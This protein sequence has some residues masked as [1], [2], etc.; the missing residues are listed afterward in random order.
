MLQ[1]TKVNFNEIEDRF[2]S[3][4]YQ[5][6]YIKP[7]RIVKERGVEIRRLGDLATRID[8]DPNFYNVQYVSDGIPVVRGVDIHIPFI[9]F[10]FSEKIT[11]ETH[12]KYQRTEVY[13]GDIIMT[14]R[15]VVG[16]TG[17]IPAIVK[18]ANISP[19]VILIRLKD[20]E[21]VGYVNLI[22]SSK[23]GRSQIKRVTV[24]SIQ[25]T[26]TVPFIE[27]LPIPFSQKLAQEVDNILKKAEKDHIK[28][29]LKL[30]EAKKLFEDALNINH[31]EVKEEK[32][33][34]VDS[35]DLTDILTPKFYYPKFLNT[36]KN[37]KKKFKTVKLGEISN[38]KRGNEVGSKNYHKYID[39]KESDIPFIRTSDLVNYEID[40]YPDYY[41]DEK[42]YNESRQDLR[43]DDLLVSNDGKIGLLAIL[44]PED[45]CIIQSHIRRVRVR[46]D[47]NPYYVLTF[48]ATDFGQ[49]QFQQYSFTQA[50]IP[51]ISDRLAE[52]EIPI[53]NNQ[54]QEK[55]SQ[56][57]KEAFLLKTEK[58]KLFR[59]ALKKVEEITD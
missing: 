10:T 11:S 34:F 35:A 23:F 30:E 24:K 49:Y 16:R 45:K 17:Q 57:V 46:R 28:A 4:F 15:G 51:T 33:Y 43:P 1:S 41:I 14:V 39:R 20:K 29:I 55:I 25:E 50:T 52:I 54:A 27:R 47:L 7:L 3:S 38:I 31:K 44:T 21:L 5:E 8:R 18:I 19:N 2:D 42:I 26:I 53:L 36:L 22:L 12:K 59:E 9:D 37:M 13:P 58:K 32:I 48:L 40:N 6:F 56:L